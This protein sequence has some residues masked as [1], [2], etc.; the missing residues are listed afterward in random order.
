[1]KGAEKL[2]AMLFRLYLIIVFGKLSIYIHLTVRHGSVRVY[3]TDHIKTL[4]IN[5][6][7][8]PA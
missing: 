4:R 6:Q 5:S 1:M 7:I 2:N 8:L 3:T